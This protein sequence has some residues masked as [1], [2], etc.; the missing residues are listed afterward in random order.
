MCLGQI[1]AIPFQKWR[2]A[3]VQINHVDKI[4]MTISSSRKSNRF[5]EVTLARLRWW[6]EGVPV[7]DTSWPLYFP[8]Y[9][10]CHVLAWWR[11]IN[12]LYR[13]QHLRHLVR[14]P[15]VSVGLATYF[16]A[17]NATRRTNSYVELA[18]FAQCSSAFAF[19]FV[20]LISS[21]GVL[22]NDAID[23]ATVVTSHQSKAVPFY[24]YIFWNWRPSSDEQVW[25]EADN[26]DC[27]RDCA[28]LTDRLHYFPCKKKNIIF[29][30]L[31]YCF[32]TELGNVEFPMFQWNCKSGFFQIN[33]WKEWKSKEGRT[34][35]ASPNISYLHRIPWIKSRRVLVL[36]Q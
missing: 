10:S 9:K 22:T 25:V 19:L 30:F 23:L 14:W 7:V 3:P 33:G 21:S 13:H 5:L 16:C 11:A 4:E 8:P 15:F 32:T 35:I 17:C 31:F 2:H 20:L 18:F 36:P 29:L 27:C 34:H 26:W 28:L 24:I 6:K 12:K 1:G